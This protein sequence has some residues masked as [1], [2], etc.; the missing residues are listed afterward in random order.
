MRSPPDELKKKTLEALTKLNIM[1]LN[2]SSSYYIASSSYYGSER[3]KTR[4]KDVDRYI[5][6]REY[7]KVIK[8]IYD[9]IYNANL[10]QPVLRLISPY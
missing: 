7:T 6:N 4:V 5:R 2:I 8:E 9:L 1:I 10:V 3:I